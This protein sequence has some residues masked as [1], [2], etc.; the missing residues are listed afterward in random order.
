MRRFSRELGREVRE[1]AP[2]AMERLRSYPWPGN[3]RELQ[4]VLK[5]ALLQAS[6]PV[7][8][9]AFLPSEL[10]SGR[11]ERQ[12]QG[13][14]APRQGTT[15]TDMEREAIQQCLFQTGGN[16][17]RTAELL[18]ISTRTLLRKIREYGL[19]DP[20]RPPAPAVDIDRAP[21]L[22]EPALPSTAVPHGDRLSPMAG[23]WTFCPGLDA[24]GRLGVA[25]ADRYSIATS[26]ISR[27]A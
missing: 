14:R 27:T 26:P 23:R 4:S 13:H 24:A 1:V 19:D 8:L 25:T 2:E 18:G 17:Q 7:L 21:S 11:G 12:R 20:L 5:Q 9:P 15:L 6:G 10:N 22:T 3:I 16:R